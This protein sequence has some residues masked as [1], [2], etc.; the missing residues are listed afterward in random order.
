[1]GTGD[2]LEVRVG[3]LSSTQV[4]TLRTMDLGV[5]FFEAR[6]L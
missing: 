5:K 2:W 1:M 3:A 4:T 6:T